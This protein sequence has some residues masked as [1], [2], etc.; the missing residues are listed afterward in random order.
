MHGLEETPREAWTCQET[1]IHWLQDLLPSHALPARVLSFG[2][3]ADASSFFGRGSSDRILEHA[4]TLVAELEADRALENASK[5]PIIF[6]CHGLG[7]ILVKRALAYSASRISKKVEHLY[8]I[9]ISTYGILFMGTPHNGIHQASWPLMAQSTKGHLGISNDL[10]RAIGKDSE[11]LQNITDQFAPLIKQFHI[12]YFWEM[13]ETELGSV[14]GFVVHED[15]AAPLIDDTE[16]SGINGTHHQMC[17]FGSLESSGYRTVYAALLRYTKDSH[18][19]IDPRW[20]EARNFLARQRENEASEL[21]GFDVHNNNQPFVFDPKEVGE[22]RNKYYHIPHNASNIYT[23]RDKITQDV[24]ERLLISS[25]N[26][27]PRQQRRYV[28]YG[29]GGSGKTQF[30]LKFVQDNR[31]R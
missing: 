6:V 5:R 9:F 1:G 27:A 25:L 20:Q 12:Y 8:S 3:T 4:H 31:D 28:L 16:R 24:R 14:K 7:G 26:D 10:L 29:T 23:G 18:A 17:K 22:I 2:Y 11:T 19:T 21:I 13:V 15:S 30:C